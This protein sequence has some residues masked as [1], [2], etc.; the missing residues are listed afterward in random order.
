M[1]EV[2]VLCLLYLT[3]ADN[4]VSSLALEPN[5]GKA[6]TYAEDQFIQ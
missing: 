2:C 6:L 1:K 5:F 4:F 3:L